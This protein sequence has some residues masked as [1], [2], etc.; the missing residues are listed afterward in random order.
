MGERHRAAALSAAVGMIAAARHDMELPRAGR[1]ERLSDAELMEAVTRVAAWLVKHGPQ[2]DALLS[3]I[4]RCA[5]LA[6]AGGELS[7]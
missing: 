6:S 5:S 4:G 7:E 2:G 3:Q 1:D